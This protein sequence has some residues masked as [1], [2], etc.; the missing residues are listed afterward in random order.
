MESVALRYA[1]SLFELAQE[2]RKIERYEAD[3][4]LVKNIICSDEE[5]LSFFMHFNV[6]KKAKKETID[7]AFNDSLSVY[8]LNFIKLLI[9]KNRMGSLPEIIQTYH[10]LTNDYLGI[11][12]GMLYSSMPIEEQEIKKLEH[13]LSTKMNKKIVLTP[14]IDESLIGGIKVVIGNHV[15]DGTVKNKMDLLKNELL[16]K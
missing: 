13:V 3:L 12:E 10:S 7:K 9:D 15:I 11:K 14:K 6:D 16:R 4:A 5:V 8:V 2:E 1:S